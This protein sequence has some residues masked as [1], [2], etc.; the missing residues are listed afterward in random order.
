M[1][2]IFSARNFWGRKFRQENKHKL[3]CPVGLRFSPGLSRGQTRFVPGTNPVKTW[4]KPRFSPC[5]TQWKPGKPGD[6]GRHRKLNVKKVY[7]PFSLARNGCANFV[8]AWHFLV[9]SESPH[10]HKIHRFRG[11]GGE[12]FFLEGGG[13]EV[14]ILFLWARGSFRNVY[15]RRQKYPNPFSEAKLKPKTKTTFSRN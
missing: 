14:P 8:G 10:A 1:S 3:F 12:C 7:V 4:D 5:F 15:Q 11:D 6:E 13:V 2:V 9:C